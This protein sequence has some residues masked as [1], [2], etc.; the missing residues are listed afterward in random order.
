MSDENDNKQ[1]SDAAINKIDTETAVARAQVEIAKIQ[2]EANTEIAKV[3]AGTNSGWQT[4][5]TA[6]ADLWEKHET[7]K[8]SGERQYNNFLTIGILI[9]LVVIVGI[10]SAL[11][12]K[13]SVTGD[14]LIFF[15]GTLAGSVL[16][17][18]AERIKT[19]K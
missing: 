19:Q 7:Q 13:G 6:L 4:V 3:Q 17:L 9:F 18:V 14:S 16:M 8:I 1:S 11:T 5:I 2:A 12:W 15:L 10:L